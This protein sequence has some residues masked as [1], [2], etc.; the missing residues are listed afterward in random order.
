MDPRKLRA[1]LLC[2]PLAAACAASRPPAAA[3]TAPRPAPP[4]AAAAPAER[5]P[6]PATGAPQATAAAPSQGACPA[7]PPPAPSGPP[8][9]S[10]PP[11]S[12]TPVAPIA[13]GAEVRD[14]VAGGAHLRL[15]TARG[16]IHV[17]TPAGY[18]AASAGVVLY[19]HGYYTDVD[20]AF[21]D[22]RLAEQFAATGRNALFVAAEAPSWNGEDV[23]WPVLSDLL[24][25]LEARGI[26]VPRG[27]VVVVGHSGA[28]RTILPWLLHPRVE[29]VVILD[30][31]YRGQEELESWLAEAAPG[32]RR[33]VLVGDETAARAETWLSASSRGLRLERVP[34][35]LSPEERS[36]P[37]VYMRSQYD[38]MSIVTEGRVMPVLLRAARLPGL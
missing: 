30:G 5:P 23:Q 38:H 10:L 20:Q 12:Q 16:S 2:A 22:H 14:T 11:W 35:A 17:W 37:L 1:A 34:D 7:P 29:E 15:G 32:A 36:A 21:A 13:A 18:A 3:V 19:V 8:D 24:H 25:E 6:A 28:I 4:P 31:L 27:P 33:V 26:P 9:R